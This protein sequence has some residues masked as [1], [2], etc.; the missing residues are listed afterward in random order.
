MYHNIP[1]DILRVMQSEQIKLGRNLKRIRTQKNIT[2][3]DIA[4]TLKVGRS[5]ITNIEN[6]KT[7]P[8]LATITRLAK[9]VGVSTNELLK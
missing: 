3:G 6:G 8:T 2:Q 1:V 5:F 7:N 4:R 9:A